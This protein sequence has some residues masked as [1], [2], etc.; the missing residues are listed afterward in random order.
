MKK[1]PQSKPQIEELA[2]FAALL[3]ALRRVKRV[4]R[5]NGEKRWEND[6]E[7][8]YQLAMLA[9]YAI[10]ALK[11]PLNLEKVLRYALAH[12]LVEVYAGDTYLFSTDEK[13]K[14]GKQGREEKARR[15]LIK[16]FPELSPLH[17][18]IL[19]YQE[20]TD[21]ES[22]FV[23][24]LDKLQPLLNIYLDDGRTWQEMEV[25]LSMI[26]EAK[27]EKVK[28]SPIVKK[29]YDQLIDLI[30]ERKEELFPKAKYGKKV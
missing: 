13:H 19:A 10:M 17:E 16:Q 11:L 28:L 4:I 7:H 27:R 29:Y 12:D 6:V 18:A 2:D 24:A 23:Y 3:N 1:R 25:T 5:A 15:R 8:S 22:Q 20:K 30:K 26:D 14:N 21:A 9:W